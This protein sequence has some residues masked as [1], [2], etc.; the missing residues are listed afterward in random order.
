MRV[1]RS[2]PIVERNNGEKSK[3]SMTI[4]SCEQHGYRRFRRGQRQFPTHGP[5]WRPCITYMVIG[6][7]FSRW[8]N[9]LQL[10]LAVPDRYSNMVGVY[11]RALTISPLARSASMHWMRTVSSAHK[12]MALGR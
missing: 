3:R 5:E 2:K 11:L 4:S 9:R 8:Y 12:K 10:G 7:S 6:K 1:R